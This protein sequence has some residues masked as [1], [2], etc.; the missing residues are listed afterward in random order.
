MGTEWGSVR[1]LC[2]FYLSEDKMTLS[3]EGPEDGTALRL[4]FRSREAKKR[5]KGRWCEKDYASCPIYRML[6]VYKYPE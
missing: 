1:V 5:C 6:M 4:I 2:P 3:C